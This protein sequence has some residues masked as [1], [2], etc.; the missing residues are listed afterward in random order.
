MVIVTVVVIQ[1]SSG[2]SEKHWWPGLRSAGEWSRVA[3]G[4]RSVTRV[5]GKWWLVH[6]YLCTA[7]YH[8]HYY[9]YYYYW[10][11]AAYSL[12]LIKYYYY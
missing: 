11:T 2:L 1:N 5:E 10:C 3:G 8:Y 6:Y 12:T 9:Y 4:G 7:A